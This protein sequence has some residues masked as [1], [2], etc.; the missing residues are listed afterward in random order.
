MSIARDWRMDRRS[1]LQSTA[2]AALALSVG[3]RPAA[4]EDRP[5][6]HN[7]L[8]FGEQTVFFSHLPMFDSLDEAARNSCHRTGF[9]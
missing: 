7:M 6:T 4:A 5:G 2:L 3:A 1:V 9:R 8:V